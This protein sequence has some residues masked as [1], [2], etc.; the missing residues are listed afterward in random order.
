LDTGQVT[1]DDEWAA[2]RKDGRMG[3]RTE[4]GDS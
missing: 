1:E 4:K 2:E 3:K